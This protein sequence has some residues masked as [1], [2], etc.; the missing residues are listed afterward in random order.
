MIL[1]LM[2]SVLGEASAGMRR[3]GTRPRMAC[4]RAASMACCGCARCCGERNCAFCRTWNW[5]RELLSEPV[6]SAVILARSG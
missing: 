3:A 6:V 2:M 5:E 1:R 4:S